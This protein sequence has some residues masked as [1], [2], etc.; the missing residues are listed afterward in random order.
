M[1]SFGKI[2]LLFASLLSFGVMFKK[3][4]RMMNEFV[5]L[6]PIVGIRDVDDQ[7][8]VGEKILTDEIIVVEWVVE[9]NVF[10]SLLGAY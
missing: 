4:V 5:L 3:C 6:N 1:C 9:L 2:K 8:E 10:P 7:N